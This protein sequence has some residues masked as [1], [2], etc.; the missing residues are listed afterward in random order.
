MPHSATLSGISRNRATTSGHAP[1]TDL[2]TRADTPGGPASQAQGRGR[3]NRRARGESGAAL[4][5]FAIVFPLLAFLLFGILSGGMVMNRREAVTH[6]AREGARYGATVA[7][8]QCTPTTNC[9]GR[10]WAGLVQA[11]TVER[12]NGDLVASQVCVALVSGAGSSTVPPTAVD[13]DHTT[14]GGTSGCYVDTSGDTSERVQ[15]SVNRPDSL[16]AI[17]I[18]IAVNLKTQ[19]TARFEP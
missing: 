13:G 5:E 14:A 11:V 17:F 4:V 7:K 18:K 16:E 9:G 10:T 2:M 3:R 8:A 19:A 15:V 1:I 6:A 12:S